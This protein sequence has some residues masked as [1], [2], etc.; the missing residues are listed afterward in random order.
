MF[1]FGFLFKGTRPF[2]ERVKKATPSC[3]LTTKLWLRL[4]P[5]LNLASQR[6][7]YWLLPTD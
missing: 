4:D 1:V 5:L 7:T 6:S 2:L 3:C